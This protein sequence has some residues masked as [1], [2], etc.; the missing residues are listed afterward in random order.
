MNISN[1]NFSDAEMKTILRFVSAAVKAKE[2]TETG[3]TDT[4]AIDLPEPETVGKSIAARING[5]TKRSWISGIDNTDREQIQ[6]W[7]KR[8]NR[9][10][11]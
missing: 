11:D 5:G 9:K 3:F 6:S 2:P 1:E 8:T 7:Y 10:R 4:T